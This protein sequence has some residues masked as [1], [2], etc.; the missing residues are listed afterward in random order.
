MTAHK[1]AEELAEWLRAQREGWSAAA[2][3]W[4]EWFDAFEAFAAPLT[5][6]L[7][8]RAQVES[9]LSV[10]DVGC[11]NGV[12]SLAA[13]RRVAPNGRV[14]GVDLA[15]PMVEN[16]RRRAAS[17]GIA[18]AE[19]RVASADDLAGLGPFDAAISRF[20]LMLVPDPDAAARSIR[21]VLRPGARFAACVWGTAPEVP[22]CAIAPATMR[23]ALGIEPAAEDAPGPTRLGAPG[24]LADVLRAGGFSDVAEATLRVE[25]RF[26][27]VEEAA[28]FYCEGSGTIR[29]ALDARA[30]ADR[31]RFESAL[32]RALS[33]C[34]CDDGSV[35]MPSTVRIAVGRAG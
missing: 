17:A 31:E 16:A 10:I 12:P 5:V 18:N 7:L 1:G 29:R 14:T 20:A 15:Q 9:G 32:Q 13:A 26:E 11:G 4:D 28:R 19:F 3:S 6:E 24:R 33:A 2:A 34:R 22:F 25:P 8:A 27:S 30:A 23:S 35:V 21:G